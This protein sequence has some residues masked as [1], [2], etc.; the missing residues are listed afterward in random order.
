MDHNQLPT[1]FNFE[2]GGYPG[3]HFSV[4][5]SGDSLIYKKNS[6]IPL[7]LVI[8]PTPE[9]WQSFWRTINRLE[10][11]SWKGQYQFPV[12][13]GTNWSLAMTYN[14]CVIISEGSNGYPGSDTAEP[15]AEF[16]RFLAA[17]SKLI[18]GLE[19]F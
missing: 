7:T 12:Y 18:G 1:T 19:I 13:D 8:Q 2:I 14:G 15:S 3:P 6:S 11:W 17:L 10:V 5:L 16:R 4:F 9:R